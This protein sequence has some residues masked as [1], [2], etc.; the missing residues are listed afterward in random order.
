MVP[1]NLHSHPVGWNWVIGPAYL[2]G[3]LGTTVFMWVQ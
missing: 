1:F 3:M 2:Q